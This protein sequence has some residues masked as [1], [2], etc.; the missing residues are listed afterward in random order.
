MLRGLMQ[1]HVDASPKTLAA[2]AN[3]CRLNWGQLHRFLIGNVVCGGDSLAGITTL[4][5]RDDLRAQ[6]LDASRDLNDREKSFA[7]LSNE[8]IKATYALRQLTII[9]SDFDNEVIAEALGDFGTVFLSIVRQKADAVKELTPESRAQMLALLN[10]HDLVEKTKAADARMKAEQQ[11][12]A[13]ELHSLI[14]EL[15]PQYPLRLDQAKALGIATSTLSDILNGRRKQEIAQT[16]IDRARA[17]LTKED[18]VELE[19][20]P[21]QSEPDVSAKQPDVAGST[22]EEGVPYVL[23]PDGYLELDY[24][25]SAEAVAFTKRALQMARAALN[26]LLAIKDPE[27]QRRVRNELGAEATET[28]LTLRVFREPENFP[29]RLSHLQSQQRKFWQNGQKGDEKP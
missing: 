12:K 18:D 2:V 15:K 11:A 19:I 8:E 3:D 13:A 1:A 6:I 14:E 21:D 26:M 28:E 22:T 9:F 16:A 27:I 25:P 17:L 24:N 20:I 23:N 4:L 7:G 29:N 10:S 5:Q